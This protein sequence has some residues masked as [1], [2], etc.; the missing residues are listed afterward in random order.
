MFQG[1]LDSNQ[2]F[3]LARDGQV[4]TIARADLSSAAGQILVTHPHAGASFELVCETPFTEADF[5]KFA[6]DQLGQ[7]VEF[8][9][10]SEADYRALISIETDDVEAGLALELACRD[11]RLKS[12][13]KDLR[14]LLG[15]TPLTVPEVLQA[16]VDQSESQ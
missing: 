15:R 6:T 14:T 3:G 4:S 11:G 12:D 1:G 8:V 9:E 13:S 5:A 7:S 16:F 10:V 2:V